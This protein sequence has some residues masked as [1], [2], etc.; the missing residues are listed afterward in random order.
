MYF[1]VGDQVR[2]D[3]PC[4]CNGDGVVRFSF[5]DYVTVILDGETWSVPPEHVRLLTAS[6]PPVPEG[7]AP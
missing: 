2:V 5:P 6:T 7:R 1:Q 3:W 4:K